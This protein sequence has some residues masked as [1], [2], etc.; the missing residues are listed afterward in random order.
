MIRFIC[1]ITANRHQAPGKVGPT[2]AIR[3]AWFAPKLNSALKSDVSTTSALSR[4]D[5]ARHSRHPEIESKKNRQMITYREAEDDEL[6]STSAVKVVVNEMDLPGH[7][8]SRVIC[9]ECGEGI[10]DGRE[11]N[12]VDEGV[13]CHSCAFG[14]YYQ[15]KSASSAFNLFNGLG[16]K[17]RLDN[18]APESLGA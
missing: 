8:R 11:L 10:N 13:L 12:T 14:T 5:S 3:R 7:P 6:F 9:Q 15:T 17:K 4:T 18:I 1:G 2:K 16:A